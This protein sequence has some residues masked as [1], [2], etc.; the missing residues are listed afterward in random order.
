MPLAAGP[1]SEVHNAPVYRADACTARASKSL[2]GQVVDEN[3]RAAYHGL[4]QPRWRDRKHHCRVHAVRPARR[5]TA[6]VEP[7]DR[8]TTQHPFSAH[9]DDPD[10]YSA[11]RPP[12][13]ARDAA[14]TAAP[15]SPAPERF[16]AELVMAFSRFRF[17]VRPKRPLLPPGRV[18]DT[19]QPRNR[20]SPLGDPQCPSRRPEEV[21]EPGIAGC[22]SGYGE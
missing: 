3:L 5:N 13:A 4:G 12:L 20:D 10:P 22:A 9:P 8:L 11:H 7:G 21:A 17:R 18:R 2:S 14:A 15:I 1:C 16:F 19:I 6:V